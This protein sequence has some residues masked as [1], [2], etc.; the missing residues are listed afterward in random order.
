M[1]VLLYLVYNLPEVIA[2]FTYQAHEFQAWR[3]LPVCA[4]GLIA[5]SLPVVFTQGFKGTAGRQAD[6]GVCFDRQR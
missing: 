1:L 6:G 4:S 5:Q 2:A 3:A